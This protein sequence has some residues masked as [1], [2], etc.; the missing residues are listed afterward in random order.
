MELQVLQEITIQTS[1]TPQDIL[2]K[3][4]FLDHR[5]DQ[6]ESELAQTEQ[7]LDQ[8]RNQQRRDRL[9][10]DMVADA[11]RY[12]DTRAPVGPP[13]S[14]TTDPLRPGQVLPD[15][16]GVGE[17]PLTLEE[18]I[19]GLQLLRE[20]LADYIVQVRDRAELFRRRARGGEWA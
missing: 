11:Q 10:Q 4:G 6:Y 14:R 20:R 19:E 16:L 2:G 3:A 7:R 13:G 9:V 15:T 5:A 18:R 17:L 12:D 8:L 1:D